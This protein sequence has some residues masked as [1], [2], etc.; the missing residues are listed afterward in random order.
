MLLMGCRANPGA[1]N[2]SPEGR[3][4]AAASALPTAPGGPVRA[5]GESRVHPDA[6]PGKGSGGSASA[7]RPMATLDPDCPLAWSVLAVGRSG[8]AGLRTALGIARR[9]LI[10]DTGITECSGV[11]PKR[12]GDVCLLRVYFYGA[13][14]FVRDEVNRDAVAIRCS[15]KARCSAVLDAFH[16]EKKGVRPALRCSGDIGHSGS[17]VRV[18]FAAGKPP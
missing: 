1:P 7:Q 13:K 9:A 14:S 15:S 18:P 2:G 8:S 3:E 17:I 12:D 4:D 11:M 10:S 5:P 6:S 16:A